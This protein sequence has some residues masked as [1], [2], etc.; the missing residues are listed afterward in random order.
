MTLVRCCMFEHHV[1]P[2]RDCREMRDRS[3]WRG[4]WA[5]AGRCALVRGRAALVALTAHTPT[6]FTGLS[7]HGSRLYKQNLTQQR[8]VIEPCKVL[9]EP[10][11][12]ERRPEPH[13]QGTVRALHAHNR[14]T[15]GAVSAVCVAARPAVRSSRTAACASLFRLGARVVS[16]ATGTKPQP[17][18]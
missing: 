8:D 10:P 11:P 9:P 17:L 14:V 3:R 2:L 1:G 13:Q 15:N 5:G 16:R 12:D 6:Y 4:V 18:V 7:A